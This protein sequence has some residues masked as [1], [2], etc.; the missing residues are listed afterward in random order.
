MPTGSSAL[1]PHANTSQRQGVLQLD[2][3]L[4][5]RLAEDYGGGSRFRHGAN[6][7]DRGDPARVL[8]RQASHGA[9]PRQGF[10]VRAFESSIALD[11]GEDDAGERQNVPSRE[12]DSNFERLALGPTVHGRLVAPHV[13]SRQHPPGMVARASFQQPW[14]AHRCGAHHDHVRSRREQSVDLDL[15]TNPAGDLDLEIVP[16][17]DGQDQLAVVTLTASGVEVDEMDSLCPG[18]GEAGSHVNRV[19]RVDRRI[20]IVS[21]Q[22]PYA[23][24]AKNVDRGDDE[25]YVY[26][27]P[28]ASLRRAS[29]V[30][31]EL[32]RD[33]DVL[34][35]AQR[36][37]H[38]LQ[39][40]F[41]LAHHAQLV[42]LDPHL[43]LRCRVL[44]LL[45][46]VASDVVGDARIQLDLDLATTL[47]HRLRLPGLEQLW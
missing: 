16:A 35:F 30:V 29:A 28:P 47:A 6:L 23:A 25:H 36:L 21:A 13:E 34:R 11:A 26:G 33:R 20:R 8:D 42:A 39:G 24:A 1:R 2:A 14:L 17:D 31:G 5:E 44:D 27:A 7:I 38:E 19:I 22:Q 12:Q 10:Q 45:S 40:V 15:G 4:V 37:D 46:E 9:H 3:T 43:D 18:G 41:V 32:Q